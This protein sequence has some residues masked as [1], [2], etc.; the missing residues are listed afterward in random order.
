MATPRVVWARGISSCGEV[1]FKGTDG[2]D[3][4]FVL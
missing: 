2:R 4:D 1:I 3:D